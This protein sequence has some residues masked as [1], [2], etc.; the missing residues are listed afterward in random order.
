ME[1]DRWEYRIWAGADDLV[2]L[3]T[4]VAEAAEGEADAQYRT[5]VYLLGT[6]EAVSAKLRF[7][8]VLEVKE[9]LGTKG[10]AEHWLLAASAEP[11]FPGDVLQRLGLAAADAGSPDSLVAAAEAKGFRA[12]AVRK[13]RRRFTLDGGEAEITDVMFEKKIFATIGI[14]TPAYEACVAI[15]ERLG[16]TE[17][18]NT[19][20]GSFLRDQLR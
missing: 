19:D 20:Y 7:G 12:L 1:D 3:S 8:R 5:D 6:D 11:P 15:A 16:L 9:L 17:Y 18:E 14:E 4:R 13:H 2:P 10:V